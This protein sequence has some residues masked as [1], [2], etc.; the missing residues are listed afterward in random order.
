M[1]AGDWFKGV[2]KKLVIT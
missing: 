2:E 1:E